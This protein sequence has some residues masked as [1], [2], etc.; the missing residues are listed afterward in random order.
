MAAYNVLRFVDSSAGVTMLLYQNAS[1]EL[2]LKAP[3]ADGTTLCTTTGWVF[4]DSTLHN[5]VITY[6]AGTIDGVARIESVAS[7]GARTT[8]AVL[9]GDTDPGLVNPTFDKIIFYGGTEISSAKVF[10]G[11]EETASVSVTV[12]VSD[13]SGEQSEAVTTTITVTGADDAPTVDAVALITTDA[14]TAKQFTLTATDPEGNVSATGWLLSSPPAKG[15]ATINTNGVDCSFDPNGEFDALGVNDTEDVTFGVTVS[16][17][18]GLVSAERAVTI[19]V[20][21]A[22][23]APVATN[24]SIFFNEDDAS[25][26]TVDLAA[27]CSAGTAAISSY[28]IVAQPTNATLDLDGVSGSCG[29]TIDTTQFQD[30]LTGQ[31]TTRPFT[32]KCTDANGNSSNVA[33]ITIH[34][35]GVDDNPTADEINLSLDANLNESGGVTYSDPDSGLFS[36]TAFEFVGS[37]TDVSS[38]STAG[39]G[40]LVWQN[41]TG[42]TVGSLAPGRFQFRSGSDF[43]TLADGLS[44]TVRQGYRVRDAEGNWSDTN[45][46]NVTVRGTYQA[47]SAPVLTQFN[48]QTTAGTPVTYDLI[49]S[50]TDADND[51]DYWSIV[52]QALDGNGA[53]KG[54]VT[55]ESDGTYDTGRVRY[56]PG[57]DFDGILAGDSEVVTA[58]ITVRDLDDNAGNTV[59]F[60]IEV[61]GVSVGSAPNANNID[62]TC[63]YDATA[64]G[65]CVATDVNNDLNAS[66]YLKASDPAKGTLTVSATGAISFDPAGAFDTLAGGTSEQVTGTYTASDDLA[67]V[68]APASIRITVTNAATAGVAPIVNNRSRTADY[69]SAGIQGGIGNHTTDAD[70]D[71]DPNGYAV[72]TNVAEGLLNFS[73]D[74][75]WTFIPNGDFDDLTSG[76]SRAVFFEATASDLQGNVSSPGRVTITVQNTSVVQQNAPV[77]A[78]VSVSVDADATLTSQQLT[79]TD[80]DGDLNASGYAT[81]TVFSPVNDG[82]LT[83][84]ADGSWSYDPNGAFDTLVT[85]NTA[86]RSFTYTA[87]D[88]AGNVSSPATVTIT[89][90]GVAMAMSE[91]MYPA[92]SMAAMQSKYQWEATGMTRFMQLPSAFPADITATQSGSWTDS[93]TWGGGGIPQAGDNV[94][95]PYGITVTFNEARTASFSGNKAYG[96]VEVRGTLQ[97]ASFMNTRLRC[98]TLWGSYSSHLKIASGNATVVTEISIPSN[99]DISLATDPAL[100]TRGIV[101]HGTVDVKDYAAGTVNEKTPF[102]DCPHGSHPTAGATSITLESTPVSWFDG[103]TF[104]V[105]QTEMDDQSATM[106]WEEESRTINGDVSTA[107]VSFTSALIYDHDDLEDANLATP[108][109]DFGDGTGSGGDRPTLAIVNMT[110][111]I[112]FTSEGGSGIAVNQRPH[113]MF[114]H[115]VSGANMHFEGVE[116]TEFGRTNKLV[117]ARTSGELAQ[118]GITLATDTNIKSRYPFHWH[119]VGFD[120]ATELLDWD[121]LP[122]LRRCVVNGSPGWGYAHHR[123]ASYTEDNIAYNVFC[124]FASETGDEIGWWKGNIG[125]RLRA[126]RSSGLTG[127]HV[128]TKNGQF[129]NTNDYWA[130]GQMYG[131][132]SRNVLVQKSDRGWNRAY[133]GEGDTFSWMHRPGNWNVTGDPN[134]ISSTRDWGLTYVDSRNWKGANGEEF[135]G[136][137]GY[138]QWTSGGQ[139]E[140]DQPGMG[141]VQHLQ[142][143]AVW[144]GIHVIK[145]GPEARH[146]VRVFFDDFIVSGCAFGLEYQYTQHYSTRRF[147]LHHSTRFGADAAK[148]G[149]DVFNNTPDML[150]AYGKIGGF[151]EGFHTTHFTTTNVQPKAGAF[152]YVIDNIQFGSQ[153]GLQDNDLDWPDFLPT[154]TGGD[155]VSGTEDRA[156]S[157][158][159]LNPLTG[160]VQ[161]WPAKPN[162]YGTKTPSFNLYG[163]SQTNAHITGRTLATQWTWASK[164]F[165]W[166]GYVTDAYGQREVPPFYGSPGNSLTKANNSFDIMRRHR[167]DMG[168]LLHHKGYWLTASSGGQAYVEDDFWYTPRDTKDRTKVTMRIYLA[169]DVPGVNGKGTSSFFPVGRSPV[170]PFTLNGVKP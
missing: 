169:S 56:S 35:T 37:L 4:E 134:W 71:I 50:T 117:R 67:N 60:D 91:P 161:T 95:I 96:F 158:T 100:L 121:N 18:T 168:W 19:R 8:R 47:S 24:G 118:E 164:N 135:G 124:A 129:I 92:A 89:I 90:N 126:R 113:V 52:S 123:S 104:I 10:T 85:G 2:E 76:Q 151:G 72:T 115:R 147:T 165:E 62:L 63:E 101:W 81:S 122:V 78:D 154:R 159:F 51:I 148:Y 128:N 65:Q 119:W 3:G 153:A 28:S 11:A 26:G 163:T 46:I 80:A 42:A 55:L 102:I 131:L 16:D 157:S 23:A 29:V 93:A 79:A 70:N 141:V 150:M 149:F 156:Y 116:I 130:T 170:T 74:G 30:L 31:S 138:S 105:P 137:L 49:N 155:G 32:F 59:N 107:A 45:Y 160:S 14:D 40:T 110:R 6:T 66:G 98:D 22:A 152:Q 162:A 69:Q 68:S 86:T 48:L 143:S 103:D 75:V 139:V 5:L 73:S 43:A 44:R 54:I 120:P 57:N 36:G 12:R 33:T 21:G 53:Q 97:F 64:T 77:V 108:S 41:A 34:I 15:V 9:V 20:T 27:L 106:N 140:P 112:K 82:I 84:N 38:G 109:N 136:S 145:S 94:K 166:R 99:G 25:E 83:V 111:Q 61:T 1:G 7:S 17:D 167:D 127:F 88:D 58:Q 114:M 39:N 142:A 125:I 132:V 133:G 13:T 146:D 144:R 87:S